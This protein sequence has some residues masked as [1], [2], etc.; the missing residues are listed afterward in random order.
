MMKDS[1]NGSRADDVTISNGF[2][3]RLIRPPSHG[4][5]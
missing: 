4:L 1:Y 5:L 3:N 2:E